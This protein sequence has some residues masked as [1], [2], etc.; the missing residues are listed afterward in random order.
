MSY[1]I[2]FPLIIHVIFIVLIA[3]RH[4]PET[5]HKKLSKFPEQ[6]LTEK[7]DYL[8]QRL[9]DKQGV[10]W[11]QRNW[12]EKLA[13]RSGFFLAPLSSLLTSLQAAR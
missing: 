1:L 11:F 2:L 6:I 3:F 10:Q 12:Q 5:I 8:T 7:R 4:N 9:E 13:R